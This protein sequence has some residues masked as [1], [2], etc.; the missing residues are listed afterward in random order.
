MSPDG[1]CP[2][3]CS[4]ELNLSMSA[5]HEGKTS[6]HVVPDGKNETSMIR[7][8]SFEGHVNRSVSDVSA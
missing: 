6:K 2:T 5:L 1:N 7:K 8:L 3:I 4:L